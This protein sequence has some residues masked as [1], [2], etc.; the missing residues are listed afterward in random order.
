MPNSLKRLIIAGGNGYLGS[1]LTNYFQSRAEEI[2][3][4]TRHH[5]PAQGNIQ[6]VTWDAE[7]LRDWQKYFCGAD[8]V[9]NLTGRSVNCRYTPE[10]KREII[11]SRVHSTKVVGEAIV[12]CENPPSIWLNASSATIY[13]A[14]F[15]EDRTEESRLDYNGFSEEVCQ[16]WEETLDKTVVPGT[17][18][19]AL[20]TTFVLGPPPCASF[21]AFRNLAMKGLGGSMAG[22]KQ[23]V[24]WMHEADFCRAVEWIIAHPDLQGSVNMTA[25]NPLTNAEF[26]R[27]IRQSQGI[28]FGLPSFRWM[29]KIGAFMMGTE[30]ELL[31]KSRKVMPKKLLDSGFTFHFPTWHEAVSSITANSS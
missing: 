23:F 8:A 12:A 13:P 6:F 4:L 14:S 31:L 26:M 18:K 17:R 1:C 9:I 25:P 29:L 20:R 16:V 28:P 27:E 22:G 5:K 3:I 15:D 10:N 11:D 30:T 2:I 24:S 21:A 7:H 19:V